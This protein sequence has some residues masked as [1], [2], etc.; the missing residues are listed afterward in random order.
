[1]PSLRGNRHGIADNLLEHDEPGVI[2]Q[3]RCKDCPL[4]Y[5]GETCR[6]VRICT[7]EHAAHTRLS[8]FDLSAVAD[9]AISYD[10]TI[11]WEKP[12]VLEKEK[13]MNRRV[14][15]E[16]SLHTSGATMN[17][18][19]GLELNPLWLSLLTSPKSGPGSNR[20]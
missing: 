11:D 3:L 5:I 19:K 17:K 10:H 20:S 14:T 8:R 2:Y 4:T 7:T 18:D 16:L 12:E 1:M 9:H 6:T 13:L 15:E